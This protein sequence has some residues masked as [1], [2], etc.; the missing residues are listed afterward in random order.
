[1]VRILNQSLD[2]V[3]F[4]YPY[5]AVYTDSIHQAD[6]FLEENYYQVY[7]NRSI[8]KAYCVGHTH[9]DVAWKWTLSVTRDKALRSFSTVL[10]LMDRYPQYRFMSS[11]PQLYKYVKEQSP[12]QF[13]RIRSRVAD[14]RWEPE[15]AMFLEADVVLTSGESLVRQIQYG[16]KFFRE[17]F[18]RD[19]R[20]LW[21]PD[22]FGYTA[23]LPQIMKQSG[24]DY[25]M[26]T[27]IGW[28]EKNCFPYDTFWWEGLDGTKSSHT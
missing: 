18:G 4:R 28:N 11:Q 3:E 27:K 6:I 13:E 2:F 8:A 23:A 1:M 5:S 16:K 25:F 7:Q 9:I 14:D 22:V 17:E 12:A 21:M 19:S 15:G 10:E 26:T 20:V 24:V